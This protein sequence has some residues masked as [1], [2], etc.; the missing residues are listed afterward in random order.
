M[1]RA[2]S[3]GFIHPDL[4]IGGAE[5]LV[6]DAALHLQR[7]GHR[8]TL[9]TARHDPT[10]CLDETRDGTLA[11]QV[12]GT[13]LPG[14]VGQRLRAP[15][16]IARMAYLAWAMTRRGGPCDVI[17]CD[18]VPHAIPF[19]RL[20]ARAKIVFYCH[21]PDRLLTPPRRLVYGLYRRPIDWLEE[22][23]TS[24]ADRV[25]VNS[26]FTA[27]AFGRIFPRLRSLRLEV[28]YPGVDVS[29]YGPPLDA[30]G[31]DTR[32]TTFLSINRFAPG[33]NV[34]LA[35]DALALLRERLSAEAFASVRLVVAGG[36][37]G[38]LRESRDTLRALRSRVQAVHLDDHV[39]FAF[40][41]SDSERLALLARCMCVVYTPADEHF[42]LAPLEAMAAGRPVVAVNSG[43]VLETVQHE[44]TGFLCEPTPQAFAAAFAR[45]LADRGAAAQMG[46]A[47]RVHVAANFSS[48][49][50]GARLDAIVRAVAAAPP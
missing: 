40:S 8:V 11:V 39:A 42:G 41:V 4:G 35:V 30:A 16:A 45:L 28:L 1:D 32:V 21:F 15:C 43:G 44:H 5:R 26:R 17:F 34:G 27:A 22:L 7:A 48:A 31:D 36:Y 50:F 38:R 29:R 20:L 49:A 24:M 12:R 9:F 19:L 18:L 37:D 14:Q 25:L 23:G 3:V 33:K 2:L 13:F 46:R 6:V 10:H 47:A